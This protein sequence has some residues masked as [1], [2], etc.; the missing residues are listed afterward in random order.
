MPIVM[1]CPRCHHASIVTNQSGVS[2]C[3]YCGYRGPKEEF[4][5][6]IKEG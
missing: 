3:K 6:D 5:E 1:R 4:E 2:V